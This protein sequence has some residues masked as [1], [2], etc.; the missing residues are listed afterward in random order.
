MG[1]PLLWHRR[2]AMMLAGQLPENIADA[3]LVLQAVQELM[4]TFLKGNRPQAPERA[5]NVLPF[6]AS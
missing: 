1:I 3:E 2:H 6:V 4:E 5:E